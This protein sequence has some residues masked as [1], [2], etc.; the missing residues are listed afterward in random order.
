MPLPVYRRRNDMDTMTML[1]WVVV[2]EVLVVGFSLI[3]KILRGR[4]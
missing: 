3:Y 2:V 1:N 4:W